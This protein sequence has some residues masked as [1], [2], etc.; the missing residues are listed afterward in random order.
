MLADYRFNSNKNG[1]ALTGSLLFCTKRRKD[2][3]TMT[4][5][6]LEQQHTKLQRIIAAQRKY[7]KIHENKAQVNKSK[8]AKAE[9]DLVALKAIADEGGL[10]GKLA[11][12]THKTLTV[13]LAAVKE[14]NEGKLAEIE[15]LHAAT[16]AEAERLE[17]DIRKE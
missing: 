9:R 11:G 12:L 10:L 13:A 7:K 17:R 6:T 4:Q 2:D 14:K 3:G 8:I 16:E 1:G 15:R 5:E